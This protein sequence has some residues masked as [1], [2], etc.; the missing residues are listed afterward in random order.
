MTAVQQRNLVT[1]S[2][3]FYGLVTVTVGLGVLLWKNYEFNGI[4]LF[5]FVISGWILSLAFHE[6]GH[7]LVAYMG[8]DRSVVEKGYLT[9]D[10]RRYVEVRTSLLFP[11]LILVLGGIGLPGGA[12]WINTHAIRSPMM[13]SLMSA[14][15][16]A[17][18]GI[19]ALICLLPIRAGMIDFDNHRLFL[20]GLGFLGAIQVIAMIFNLVPVP[21]LDGFGIIE[22]FLSN[23]TR[24]SLQPARQY[25][26][27]IFIA[28][29]W[30]VPSVRDAFWSITDVF[31]EAIG[32]PDIPFLRSAGFREF[33]F[34]E[35]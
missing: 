19:C 5:L 24:R 34:W 18:S 2:P 6:F 17:A 1:P 7:A 9:L 28:A 16:P 23:E 32:G 13:R 11:I 26:I 35:R 30:F 20:L 8:G 14:A 12:V 10:V 25:G 4:T 22:P 3:V 15:G 21:G 31:T 27:M 29:I 33:Q